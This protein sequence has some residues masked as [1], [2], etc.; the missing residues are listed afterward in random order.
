MSKTLGIDLGTSTT[1]IYLQSKGIV[2][3]ES[4]A[5]AIEASTFKVIATGTEARARLGR[6]PGSIT[7]KRPC[8]DGTTDYN[9]TIELM[10]SFFGKMKKNG[11]IVK[12]P[13]VMCSVSCGA[14]D[15]ERAALEDALMQAGCKKV[16]LIDKP[17]AAA[18]GAKLDINGTRPVMIAD[19]GS[20]ATEIAVFSGGNAVNAVSIN[21]GG[22][23]F[24]NALAA[25]IR[26]KYNL[27]ISNETAELLKKTYGTVNEKHDRGNAVVHGRN[28]S[29]GLPATIEISSPEIRK[30]L[31]RQIVKIA[32]QL[33]ITLDE[34]GDEYVEAI[35]ENGITISGGS[36]MLDGID[37][38]LSEYMDIPV[39]TAVD[40]Q[41]CIIEGL[42]I[43]IDSDE[44]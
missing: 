19:I 15:D 43:L 44:K 38:L 34:T 36:A 31:S 23:M 13:T 42:G 4:T 1:F 22:K 24:S 21:I 27:F 26:S 33:L 2:V 14:D 6:I 9:A 30:V 18:L 37:M 17:Y 11:I 3:R 20:G 10:R 5:I 35:V 8:S 41:D 39:T 32:E 12:R 40:P 16:T 7:I 25:Y 29:T 28:Y